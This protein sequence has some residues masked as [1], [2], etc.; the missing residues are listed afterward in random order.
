MRDERQDSAA[1]YWQT[2]ELAILPESPYREALAELCRLS[3][4]RVE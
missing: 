1:Q 3:V 4:D 2:A